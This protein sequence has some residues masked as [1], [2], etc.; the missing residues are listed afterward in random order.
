MT[1]VSHRMISDSLWVLRKYLGKTQAELAQELGISQS[2]L[3]EIE[4][5]SK[6]VTFSLLQK[7]SDRFGVPLSA[8]LF[9][10]EE[11]GRNITAGDGRRRAIAQGTLTVLKKILP[12]DLHVE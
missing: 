11:E 12:K 9:F 2:Y 5:G 8:L 7:Y 1:E 6:E 3:S 4:K 10:V